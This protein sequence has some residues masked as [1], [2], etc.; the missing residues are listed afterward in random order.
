MA[1]VYWWA[2]PKE[3]FTFDAVYTT[4]LRVCDS[5]CGTRSIAVVT[6]IMELVLI[7]PDLPL[8]ASAYS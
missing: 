6:R 4:R 5:T 7:G 2:R 8:W 3:R 1:E